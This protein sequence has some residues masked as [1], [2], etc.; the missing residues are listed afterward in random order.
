MARSQRLTSDLKSKIIIN[1]KAKLFSHQDNVIKNLEFELGDMAY[2]RLYSENERKYLAEAPE[3][4]FVSTDDI[5]FYAASGGRRS[6]PLRKAKRFYYRDVHGV[7]R[8]V[9]RVE[10]SPEDILNEWLIELE[11]MERQV[12]NE[13]RELINALRSVMSGVTTVNRLIEVWP[14]CVEYLPPE[15]AESFPLAIPVASLNELIHRLKKQT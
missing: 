5:W 12:S 3:G 13:K 8:D 10:N 9:F 7:P 14:E 4:A 2:N 1:A 11:K 15:E 6:L